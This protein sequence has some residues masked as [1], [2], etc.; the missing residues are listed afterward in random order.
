MKRHQ[1]PP[2]PADR[3]TIIERVARAY[4]SSDLALRREGGIGD[5][6]V[7][8]ATGMSAHTRRLALELHRLLY[9]Q[10]HNAFEDARAHWRAFVVRMAR[11][12]G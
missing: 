7:L 9:A 1:R 2:K 8:L 6:E 12:E 4:Q 11:R 10:D 3:P 5:A